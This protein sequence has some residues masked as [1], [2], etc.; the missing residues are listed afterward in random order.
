MKNLVAKPEVGVVY[1]GKVKGIKPFGAFVEILPG[2]EG[3][4]H[5]S[6]IAKE[7]IENEKMAAM[8]DLKNL[9][10]HVLRWPGGNLSNSYF[11]N[12]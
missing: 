8:T 11:W 9:D 3:L 10:P 5:I 12:G 6:R 2:K 7:R 1:S 4:L